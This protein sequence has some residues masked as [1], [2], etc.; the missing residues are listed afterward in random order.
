MKSVE[1]DCTIEEFEL[2][3]SMAKR[4]YYEFMYYAIKVGCLL[5]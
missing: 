5:E 4:E 3:H 2:M 1:F